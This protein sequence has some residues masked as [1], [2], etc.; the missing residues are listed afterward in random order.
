VDR[1]ASGQSPRRKLFRRISLLAATALAGI[2]TLSAPV[3]QGAPEKRPTPVDEPGVT[4]NLWKRNAK[5]RR[6][7]PS[8]V[9]AAG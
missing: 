8:G 9:L 6:D 4:A 1:T 7:F 5:R 3:A 2:L